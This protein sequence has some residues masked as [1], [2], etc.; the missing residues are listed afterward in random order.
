[1]NKTYVVDILYMVSV[2]LIAFGLILFPKVIVSF[3]KERS[4]IKA[5]MNYSEGEE[6]NHW[7]TKLRELYFRYIPLIGKIFDK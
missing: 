2:L 7:K 4:Y 6:Y 3:S 1:M 5:E